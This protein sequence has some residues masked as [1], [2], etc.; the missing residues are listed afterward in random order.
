MWKEDKTI[1]VYLSQFQEQLNI[2]KY[3]H[4]YGGSFRA[5]R[6]SAVRSSR[7]SHMEDRYALVP[8]PDRC[9]SEAGSS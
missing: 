2:H 8:T 9:L 5:K 6:S 3:V 7:F 1:L 4:K